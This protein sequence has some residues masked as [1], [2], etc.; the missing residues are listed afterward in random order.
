MTERIRGKLFGDASF[1]AGRFEVIHEERGLRQIRKHGQG[2]QR[3]LR[4]GE[5]WIDRFF[6]W[7]NFGSTLAAMRCCPFIVATAVRA[8]LHGGEAE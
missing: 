7:I 2:H 6:L 1:D 4:V 5:L 3:K 8:C